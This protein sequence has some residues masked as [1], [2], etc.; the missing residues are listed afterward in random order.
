MKNYYTF[1]K[2]RACLFVFLMVCATVYTQAATTKVNIQLPSYVTDLQN[3]SIYVYEQNPDESTDG[4]VPEIANIRYDYEAGDGSFVLETPDG[5]ASGDYYLRTH[6]EYHGTTLSDYTFK[7]RLTIGS[8]NNIDIRNAWHAVTFKGYDYQ[9]NRIEKANIFI[10]SREINDWNIN[11]PVIYLTSGKHKII[12][13]P[14]SYL[15]KAQEITID[16]DNT[17]EFR[18]SDYRKIRASVTGY[19]NAMLGNVNIWFDGI[20]GYDFYGDHNVLDVYTDENG[21]ADV[22]LPDGDISAN[23]DPE[24]PYLYGL[25]RTV[26]INSSV[27]ALNFSFA[28]Y[29]KLTTRLVQGANTDVEVSGCYIMRENNSET[30]IETNRDYYLPKG[31]YSY[32]L[33]GNNVFSQ[34]GVI[35][36]GDADVEK[37]FD[38]SDCKH[39]TIEVPNKHNLYQIVVY[40][41]NTTDGDFNLTVH[42]TGDGT[43][44]AIHYECYLPSGSYKVNGYTTANAIKTMAV[45]QDNQLFVYDPVVPNQSDVA[46]NFLNAPEDFNSDRCYIDVTPEGTN[47][48]FYLN[49]VGKLNTGNYTYMVELSEDDNRYNGNITGSFSIADDGKPAT[50]NINLKDYHKVHFVGKA[51]DGKDLQHDLN[52]CMVGALFKDGK[53][54]M[55]SE[56]EY[57]YNSLLPAGTYQALFEADDEETGMF[58]YKLMSFTVTDNTPDVMIQFENT[59]TGFAAAAVYNSNMESLSDAQLTIAGKQ[60]NIKVDNYGNNYASLFTELAIGDNSYNLSVNGYK[61]QTGTINVEKGFNHLNFYVEEAA[62]G[63]DAPTYNVAM[64]Q[65]GDNLHIYANDGAN[66]TASVYSVNGNMVKKQSMMG[67]GTMSVS[68]LQ[69]GI[70]IMQLNEGGKIKTIKFLKK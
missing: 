19:G 55:D 41:P 23:V 63:I 57:T 50:I 49:N 42:R 26:N 67:N 18:F 33:Y 44:E 4:Y 60:P 7:Q 34:K 5:L 68:S 70:Y 21:I 31:T 10:D 51:P 48:V 54:V 61:S 30:S 8:T 35:R 32:E 6:Y 45:E 27:D 59:N 20:G 56:M 47:E 37:V 22:Y 9:G 62:S 25:E 64:M 46:V 28:D 66:Y 65:Q 29:K 69:S 1:N 3:F 58:I 16:G 53:I 38:F 14:D 11:T 52:A 36:I 2:M 40:N 43:S 17:I 12:F 13:C 15:P 39:V 24:T